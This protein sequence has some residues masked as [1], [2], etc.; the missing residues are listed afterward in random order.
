MS[1]S[2]KIEIE[3]SKNKLV[4]MVLGSIIFVILGIWYMT[5]T[6]SINFPIFNNK[7]I[8][9]II[10]L[11]GVIFFGFTTI[12]LIKKLFDKSPGIIITEDGIYD[13][14]SAVSL[15]FIPWTD[16]IEIK[17]SKVFTESF[18]N[19]VLKNPQ[20]YIDK[21]KYTLR[22]KYIR[23][24]RKSYDSLITISANGLNI[25]HSELKS[26]IEKSFADF[27]RAC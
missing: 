23:T 26:L 24:N 12:Y 27:R 17:T 25:N 2:Y 18:V 9:F 11:I 16:I 3:I 4:R 7:T 5:Q 1:N 15:G 19:I 8:V 6:P 14:S 13:N 20:A 22:R 10:G 21:Y